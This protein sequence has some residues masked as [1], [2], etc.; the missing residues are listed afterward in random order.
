MRCKF[1]LILLLTACFLLPASALLAADPSTLT[2]EIE[3]LKRNSEA[4]LVEQARLVAE[5]EKVNA[6][7][8]SL[9]TAVKS[10]DT[11]RKKLAA[12]IKVTQSKINSTNLNIR[13]LENNMADKERAIG[14]H[15]AA[16]G[17]ALKALH[18]YDSRS[19]I[20]DV[21]SSDKLSDFWQ[22]RG[23]LAELSTR[24]NKEV[25]SLR[26][27]KDLLNEEKKKKEQDKERILTLQVE[28]NGQKSVVEESKK[29]QE[30]LLVETKNREATYQQMLAENLA[31]QKQFEEDLYRLESELNITLDPTLIPVSRPG[32]L[33]WPLDKVF[34]TNYFGT[35][36]G[37]RRIYA[38]GFHNGVDFRAAM[39]TPVLAMLSGVV[40]GHGNTDEQR[41]CYSYGRWI[42]IKHGNG[43]S[44]I[45]AHLSVSLVQTGQNVKQGDIIGYSGG[46]KG[47][48]GSG[49]ST[50]PHL[51]VGLF[52][53]QGVAIRQF[54]TSRGCQQVFVPISD[55]KAY[56]DPLAY[57]P[58]I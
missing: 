14:T 17:L 58:S 57:L 24:L 32:V 42:L 15:E 46:Q 29:A 43:L 21:L 39:G 4:L 20:L 2:R 56:L 35:V 1:L 51:H 22:D 38:S 44:S 41:G 26:E 18:D 9:G 40:E 11:T 36:S 31:R 34:I 28:L 55:V 6:Q 25:G 23:E 52:A 50:G 53:S 7:S 27:T 5:L 49:Y 45:Y 30:K 13:S 8:Q 10:L 12:D 16:I 37:N 19:L 54:V 33:S 3:Q 47:V 48:F